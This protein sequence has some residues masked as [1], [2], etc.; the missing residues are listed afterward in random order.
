MEIFM[1]ILVLNGSPKGKYSITLHTVLYL[2]KRFPQCEFKILHVG[3]QIKKYQK[4]LTEVFE[5]I[6]KADLILFA[7]PVYTF[8]APYQL[9]RF[10]ELIKE[11]D[12]DLSGKFATQITTSKHF[13]DVMA[14]KYIEQNCND[15][16]L[17]YIRGLSADMDDLLTKQGQEDAISYWNFV[18]HSVEYGLAEVPKNLLPKL[19]PAYTA[20]LEA[21][22]KIE[23]FE[24]VI[25]TNKTKG[26]SSLGAMIEDFRAVY[27]YRTKVINI[28]EYPFFSG[29]CLGCFN[30][31]VSGK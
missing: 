3:Q 30:C 21:V 24:T 8:I 25:V 5:A 1:K 19:L 11:T 16:K 27:P 20:S 18:L 14:H 31:A 10:I 2:E 26:D 7:Y 22:P 12:I 28:A 6:A 17:R 9:H 29:G 15:L 4:D 13:Y 23:G